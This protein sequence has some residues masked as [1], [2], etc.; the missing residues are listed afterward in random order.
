MSGGILHRAREHQ[1]HEDRRRG[2]EEAAGG[3]APQ[4]DQPDQED[5]RFGVDVSYSTYR[6]VLSSQPDKKDDRFGVDVSYM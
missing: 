4:G 6:P 2:Q 1:Q 3:P 5:D